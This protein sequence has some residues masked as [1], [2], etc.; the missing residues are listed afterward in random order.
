M[1]DNHHAN[2]LGDTD[3][4][5][6][7]DNEEESDRTENTEDERFLDE[8]DYGQNMLHISTKQVDFEMT[9]TH[10]KILILISKYG[11]TATAEEP[12]ESWI[13]QLPLNV[14]MYEGITAGA[15]D[16]DYSPK[17]TLISSDGSFF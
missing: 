7:N 1:D 13:R 3:A 12:Q 2:V 10:S 14:L 16:C 8:I 5:F 9:P 6:D 4:Y 11:K 15:I 17:S